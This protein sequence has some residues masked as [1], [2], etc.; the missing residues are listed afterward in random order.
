MSKWINTKI[1]LPEMR[2]RVLVHHDNQTK[3]GYREYEMGDSWS[4]YGYGLPD[5][6]DINHWQLLPEPPTGDE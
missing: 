2:T 4:W 1:K 3:I 6:P 5:Y